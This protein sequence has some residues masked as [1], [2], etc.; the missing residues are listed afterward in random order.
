M[1]NLNFSNRYILWSIIIILILCF[2]YSYKLIQEKETKVNI[3][4]TFEKHSYQSNEKELGTYDFPNINVELESESETLLNKFFSKDNL[5]LLFL[6]LY[7]IALSVLFTYREKSRIS[8][9]VLDEKLKIEKERIQS[10]VNVYENIEEEL[11]KYKNV[12]TPELEI[13]NL[14]KKI[15]DEVNYI[16]FSSRVILEKVLLSICNSN[17][18]NEDTLN[19]MIFNLYKKKILD[20]QTNGYAH[21][22]KA[23]GNRV[24]HPSLNKKM[25]FNAKDALLVLST[26]VALLN[27]LEAKKLLKGFEN[28]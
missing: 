13:K 17:E 27:I 7:S 9:E 8:K 4:E 24:A 22:I 11:V 3:N 18:I 2:T 15:S 20:P 23:F 6:L 14:D 28:A 25:T 26:L 19:N 10:K 12:V 1:K 21:T 5:L 16:L